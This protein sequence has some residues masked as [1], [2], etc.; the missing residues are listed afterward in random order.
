M[1]LLFLTAHEGSTVCTHAVSCMPLWFAPPSIAIHPLPLCLSLS[2]S[3]TDYTL[4]LTLADALWGIS[5]MKTGTVNH[6]KHTGHRLW[7]TALC[8]VP[9]HCA[10]SVLHSFCPLVFPSLSLFFC[11]SAHV[12]GLVVAS[13]QTLMCSDT[14]DSGAEDEQSYHSC[15]VITLKTVSLIKEMTK[16]FIL[17]HW[18]RYSSW[19]TEFCWRWGSG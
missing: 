3:S 10:F 19:E 15:S 14:H 1:G 4:W 9:P 8:F 13:S 7:L 16:R 17:V 11:P 6:H 5:I 18:A 12:A 2:L